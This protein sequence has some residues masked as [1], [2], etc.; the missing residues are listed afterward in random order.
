MASESKSE[1]FVYLSNKDIKE[2]GNKKVAKSTNNATSNAV[3]TFLAFCKELN[4]YS[5]NIMEVKELANVLAKFYAGCRTEKGELYKVNSMNSLRNGLQ[6]HF[7]IQR[8]VDIVKDDIFRESNACFVNVVKKI[9]G[10]IK[11][12]VNHYPEIEPED[13]QKLYAS[14]DLKT[15][16]GLLEKVWLDVMVHFI[17]RG[18]ENLRDMTIDTFEIGS[19]A[20]GKRFVYQKS[21]EIDKNHSEND[22]QFDTI[23]EGRMYETGR[24][25]CPF[26]S[27]MIYI[28]HLNPKQPA[29]WQRPKESG[30]PG[31]I[32]YDNVP[33][34]AK[35]LGTML[36]NM[37]VKYQLSQR[38]TNHSVRV[39]SLQALEDANVEGRHIIRISGHKSEESIK[40][41]A[42]KLSAARKR[43]ISA[44]L[45]NAVDF[46]KENLVPTNT[47]VNNTNDINS[48]SSKQPRKELST[49]S[50]SNKDITINTSDDDFFT[51]IPSN[52]LCSSSTN[53]SNQPIFHNCQVT[54]NY[55]YCKH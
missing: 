2:L 53:T 46:N 29:F 51:Q 15:P 11:G 55:N 34:G 17:R 44:V 52:L 30:A 33:L 36:S 12:Q 27:F 37:S 32:W 47:Q 43:S 3:K 16:R 13:V 42:R 49:P 24:P 10:T 48:S 6:R 54:I 22:Q 26:N 8:N 21:G 31:G 19:D 41:Y 18:R 14:V 23:G 28:S 35:N 39:T 1:R 38:Y 50:I 9:R 25:S 7:I 5:I 20:A 45:S 4:I 40:C